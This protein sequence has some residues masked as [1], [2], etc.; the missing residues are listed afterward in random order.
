MSNNHLSSGLIFFSKI[1]KISL[2]PKKRKMRLVTN[3]GQQMQSRRRS[4]MR[5]AARCAHFERQIV[6]KSPLPRKLSLDLNHWEHFW[7]HVEQRLAEKLSCN[8]SN[9]FRLNQTCRP[10]PSMVRTANFRSTDTRWTPAVASAVLILGYW[11]DRHSP[12]IPPNMTQFRPT[13]F[14]LK[15]TL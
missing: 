2:V 15:A 5:W 7:S 11:P 6:G 1:L 3:T 9:D 10:N 4:Q 8:D 12:K 14:F 13:L